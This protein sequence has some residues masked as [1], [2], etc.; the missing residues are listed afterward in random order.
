M[1]VLPLPEHYPEQFV[2]L[3]AAFLS[4]A[5]L[6]LWHAY[7]DRRLAVWAAIL[8]WG[9]GMETVGWAMDSHRHGTFALQ[10]TGFLPLKEAVWYNLV[11]YPSFVAARATG[12]GRAAQAAV[13][14]LLAIWCDWGYEVSNSRPCV[15]VVEI[16]HRS[17][18][19]NLG[20]TWLTGTVYIWFTFMFLTSTLYV[21]LRGI[22]DWEQRRQSTPAGDRQVQV[23]TLLAAPALALAAI[24]LQLLSIAPFAL[25]QYLFCK[26][27]RLEYCPVETLVRPSTQVVL[28]CS[29]AAILILRDAGSS[30]RDARPTVH[31][32]ALASVHVACDAVFVYFCTRVACEQP[33]PDVNVVTTICC[34]AAVSF[35]AVHQAASGAYARG[36]GSS[37]KQGKAALNKTE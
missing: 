33:S 2:V 19:A 35:T 18:A 7:V 3:E 12:F 30:P 21:V 20:E 10:V 28:L 11:V 5:A 14:G 4:L 6:T 17:A 36:I 23:P 32:G 31:P 26:S 9:V 22:E 37:S 27:G 15:G 34:F 25:F 16:D 24:P 13:T 1:A 29:L 8:A